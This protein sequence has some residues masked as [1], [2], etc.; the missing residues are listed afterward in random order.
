MSKTPS[1]KK[2][3]GLQMLCPLVAMILMKFFN[4]PPEVAGALFILVGVF[5]LVPMLKWPQFQLSALFW[6]TVLYFVL[7]TAIY[8]A[9]LGHGRVKFNTFSILGLPASIFHHATEAL[10][11]ALFG[12]TLWEL[13]QIRR[14]NSVSNV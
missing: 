12:L 8:G 13:Y 7:G 10:Y 11:L 4:S 3:I 14:K 1:L 5:M 2:F 9:W 6:T